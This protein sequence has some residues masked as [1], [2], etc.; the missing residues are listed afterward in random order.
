MLCRAARQEA[1]RGLPSRRGPGLLLRERP[2]ARR[3]LA[4]ADR[5]GLQED[6][7]DPGRDQGHQD[8]I[9]TVAGYSLLSGASAPYNA[10]YFVA[11]DPWDERKGRRAD[12]E[13]IMQRSTARFAPDPGGERLRLPASGDPGP[14]HGRRLLLLAPGPQRRNG[15]VPRREPPEVPGG[16]AQAA[17][18]R[19][20]QRVPAPRVPQVFADVDRDKVLKQGVAWAT[21]TRRCRRSSAASTSTSSTASGASGGSSCRPSRESAS[22]LEDIGAVLRAQRRRQHGALSTRRDDADDRGPEFTNRFNLFRAAQVTGVARAR[23]QLGP[24]H[25]GARGGRARGPAARDG[26]RLGRHVVPGARPRARRARSSCSRS[27]S[28]S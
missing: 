13:A 18:A 16:R 24:G 7:E 20:R 3:L 6:R 19:Q 22:S 5:R 10:F 2:A 25:G 1:A 17:G 14:R 8:Y 12:V 4:P 15:R 23:L 26:L 21:C 28:S 9:T 11:L 27:S